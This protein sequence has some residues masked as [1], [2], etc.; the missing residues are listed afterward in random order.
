M[1]W[2]VGLYQGHLVTPALQFQSSPGA[3][4]PGTYYNVVKGLSQLFS[5]S[6]ATTGG[7]QS[8][9]RNRFGPSA[10]RTDWR[11]AT[12]TPLRISCTN[13]GGEDNEGALSRMVR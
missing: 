7:L 2:R 6:A 10:R 11:Q 8:S 9:G 1:P 3:E 4:A 12:N 5:L 13:S